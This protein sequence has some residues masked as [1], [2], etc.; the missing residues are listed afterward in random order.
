MVRVAAAL[1]K[2]RSPAAQRRGAKGDRREGPQRRE[3]RHEIA[4]IHANSFNGSCAN[5]LLSAHGEG[6]SMPFYTAEANGRPFVVFKAVNKDEAVSF[7]NNP[8]VVT[9]LTTRNDVDG[10]L[11]WA[12][13]TPLH[14]RPAMGQEYAKWLAAK[15]EASALVFLIDDTT[16]AP[17]RPGLTPYT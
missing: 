1:P 3:R 6:R 10:K 16:R 7:L 8:T 15:Q 9:E 11:I 5:M 4:G 12:G 14:I 13:V 2:G 17:T